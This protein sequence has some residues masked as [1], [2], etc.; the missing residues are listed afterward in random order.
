MK[1]KDWFRDHK[2]FIDECDTLQRKLSDLIKQGKKIA[3]KGYYVV[4]I[5]DSNY[6]TK[7]MEIL[8]EKK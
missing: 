7:E 6:P 5:P 8:L 2:K 3:P 1:R 4:L